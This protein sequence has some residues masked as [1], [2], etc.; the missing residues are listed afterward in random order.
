MGEINIFSQA[1]LSGLATSFRKIK[2]MYIYSLPAV[3]CLCKKIWYNKL[4]LITN[5]F[6]SMICFNCKK[7]IPDGVSVC[8][9]CGATINPQHQVVREIKQRRSQRWIFYV[10]IA[11]VFIGMTSYTVKVVLDNANSI[12]Q[13]TAIQQQ[14]NDAKTKL[15]QKDNQL[16]Q[17]ATQLQQTQSQIADLQKSLSAGQQA[18][19]QKTSDFQQAL[20]DKT[21]LMTKYGQFSANLGAD[22][23]NV[24]SFLV[25]QGIGTPN[26]DLA[27]I[28]IADFNL[29]S[30]KDSDS[31]GLSDVVEAALGTNPNKADTNGNGFNDK[32]ELFNGYDPV[33]KGKL[34]IDLKFVD[35]N[36]GKILLEIDHSGEAWYVNPKDGKKYFLGRPADA[37]KTLQQI[38]SSATPNNNNPVN[39]TASTS[40]NTSTQLD[41]VR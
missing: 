17:S 23:A 35:A 31:D 19:D 4:N 14:M 28:P 9:S 7:Q 30:G 41:F 6:K 29:N 24:Y 20:A 32:Q 38:N 39:V 34:P 22:N 13:I 10:I 3:F 8:P 15:S 1:K 26:K 25:A 5:Y 27:K 11:A 18:L 36:K 2:S 12:A 21:D 37:L 40:I 33:G 16:Q